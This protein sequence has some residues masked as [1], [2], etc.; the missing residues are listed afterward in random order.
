MKQTIYFVPFGESG[1]ENKFFA[2]F[3]NRKAN[4]PPFPYL[5]ER[6]EAAG[7]TV[8]TIDF[9]DEKSRRDDDILIVFDHPPVGIY[10]F[11]Y[12]FRDL[13]RRKDTFPLKNRRLL[14]LLPQFRKRVLMQWESA[15][16]NPWVYKNIKSIVAHYDESYFIPKASGLPHFY[17]PQNFDRLNPEHFDKSSRKFMVMMNSK[18]KAKG[19]LDHELYSERVRALE[20]FSKYDEV[21]LYGPRWDK[22]P[23][24]FIKKI[25][26]GFADDKPATMSK[27]TFALC[28]ENAIWPGYVTEKIFDCMLVGT[29]PVYWGAPDIE[30]DVPADCFVDMR[31]F[32]RSGGSSK[33][34][35]NYEELRT[36]LHAITPEE[37]RGYKEAI[38]T[39]FESPDFKKFTPEFFVETVLKIIHGQKYGFQNKNKSR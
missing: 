5:K 1:L 29:I 8:R 20:F 13:I 39:Y 21:D 27:Y 7:Y 28:F 11:L 19:F 10:K 30:E 12:R 14:Q 4:V 16:N 32:S 26:R 37:I 22:D 6:L 25:W 15:V 36:L 33:G 2:T 34:G 23:A 38:R 3:S 31:K 9:W 24:P 18:T 17:Y 35:I